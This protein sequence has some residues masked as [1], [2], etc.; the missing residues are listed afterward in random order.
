MDYKIE[1]F[2][3][4]EFVKHYIIARELILNALSKVKT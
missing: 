2:K 4:E 1:T 3:P